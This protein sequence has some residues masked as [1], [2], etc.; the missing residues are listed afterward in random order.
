MQVGSCGPLG[1]QVTLYP[2]GSV[3]AL[4]VGAIDVVASTI[5]NRQAVAVATRTAKRFVIRSATA[6]PSEMCV[7]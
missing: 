5:P 6:V 7:A 4:A 2:F 3:S 1:V